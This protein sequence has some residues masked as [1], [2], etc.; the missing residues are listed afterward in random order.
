MRNTPLAITLMLLPACLAAAE[1][2]GAKK[3]DDPTSSAR[4]LPIKGAAPG[5]PCAVYGADFTR[6]DGTETCVKVGGAIR[7]E[8]GSS[9]G[10]R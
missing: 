6:L 5:N 3:P 8:A 4:L 1:T 2:T 9:L 7:I 10:H